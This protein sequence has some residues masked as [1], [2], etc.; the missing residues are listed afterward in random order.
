MFFFFWKIG[1]FFSK[2]GKS[3]LNSI[4]IWGRILAREHKKSV[5]LRFVYFARFV[6]SL[7]VGIG[8]ELKE[9]TG[10]DHMKMFTMSVT[11][12]GQEFTGTAS[13]KKFLSE[14][15]NYHTYFLP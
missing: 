8:Y 6:F 12:D 4:E 2:L 7:F 15:L 3:H 10:E 13:C 1:I 5:I 14:V 9:I 11:I